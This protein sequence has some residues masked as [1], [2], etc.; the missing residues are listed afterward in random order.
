MVAIVL[1]DFQKN[2]IVICGTHFRLYT[3]YDYF[4]SQFRI[5]RLLNENNNDIW[6]LGSQDKIEDIISKLRQDNINIIRNGYYF[7]FAETT[8][9]YTIL[10]ENDV[11]N[12]KLPISN[13]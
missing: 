10:E 11:D 6:F 13:V 3:L 2:K 8:P 1:E 7:G 9:L 4:I 12:A 5:Q